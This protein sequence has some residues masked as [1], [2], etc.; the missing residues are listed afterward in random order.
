MPQGSVLGVIV[1]LVHFEVFSILENKLI[2]YSDDSTLMAVVSSPVVRVTLAESLIRDIW[3]KKLNASKSNPMIVSRSRTMQPR[4]PPLTIRGTVLKESDD[5]VILGVTLDSKM[6][7]QKHL[8][9]VS[10]VASQRLG[11]LRKFWRVFRDRSLLERY[12]RGFVLHVLEYCSAVWCSA[13]DTHLKLLDRAV[14]GARFLTGCVCECDIAHRRSVAVLCVLYKIRCNP[15]HR[16]N[17]ALLGAYV[18][19]LVTPCTLVALRYTCVPPRSTAGLLLPSQ[20]LS[21][22]ILLTPY[23]MVWDW[24]V[25]RTW[26]MLFF[27]GLSC[28]IPTIVFY[29]FSLFIFSVYR[30]LLWGQGSSE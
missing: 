7:F 18:P 26:P 24:R 11:I 5:L 25:S 13:V 30:L 21:G 17:D 16:L 15:M 14:S 4:S 1:P 3:G 12:V 22:T 2:G 20:C 27:I 28:S 23:S 10:K 6:T 8:R 9:L 29:Y 19:V